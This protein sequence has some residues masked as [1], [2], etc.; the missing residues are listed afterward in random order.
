MR[1]FLISFAL[2]S[3]LL[4]RDLVHAQTSP[5]FTYTS[6]N[7]MIPMRDGVRLFTSI[8]VPS[9][10]Q[11]DLPFLMTRTPY[12]AVQSHD[13][14]HNDYIKDMAS[15]GYIFV[16][17]D[18]RGRNK[19]EG[20]YEMLRPSL[21]NGQVGIDESTDTYDT[22]DWLL[23]NIVGNN[24]KVGMY[25]ISYDGWTTLMGII[26]PHPALK[27]A[28]P[29]ASPADMFLGDDFHHNGA[30][31]LSYS[32]EYAFSQEASKTDTLFPFN[33]YDTFDWYLQ[34]GPLSNVNGKY[35][36]STLPSWNNF[37][38]HPN[39]D[40]FWQRQS[41]TARLSSNNVPILNVAGWWDQEDFYG[42][43][44]I[45]QALEKID[46]DKINQLVIGPWHHGQWAYWLGEK[47]GNINFNSNTGETFRKEIQA[48]WFAYHLK[49]KGKGFT[50]EAV[51]F[52]TGSNRWQHYDKWPPAAM[53]VKNLYIHANGKLSF[54]KPTNKNDAYDYYISD[55][56]HP[57]PYRNRPIEPTN[58]KD[59]RWRAW[60]TED[61][62]FVKDRP[63]VLS[64]QTDPLE[65]D[66][67]VTGRIL[68]NLYAATSGS[69]ADWIV[70]LIDVYPEN[71]PV[72][73][74][75]G[76]YELMVA[77]E[78]FRGRY[79]K[80]FE[81]PQ[82]IKPNQVNL[83]PIDLHQI[84]HVFKKGHRVMVQVQSSWFPLIDR[85]PQ[86]YVPSIFT[87]KQSDYK[88]AIHKISRS[89]RFPTHI[90]LQVTE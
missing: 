83:Y 31:R 2:L 16:F 63:D 45:Y 70:K 12:D 69:D 35:F 18:I 30:F 86:S 36:H 66:L 52:Q 29:Q 41:A 82:P 77:N 71:I 90:Q 88:S 28:S 73:P 78:V 58:S 60:L 50:S 1:T 11:D 14:S 10:H 47:L 65:D 74:T 4:N 44:S 85:N 40:G 9:Q 49:G 19:S 79:R 15:E 23:K 57:V 76:G 13:P 39:Y 24:G 55:P 64:W 20:R 84:D 53:R 6:K 72:E 81:S 46:K 22:I 56:S 67:T 3:G 62:R 26:R 27:A 61:Q 25:G 42:P 48:P 59:S 21:I 32:F 54:T 51:V 43:L 68:A 8:F 75:M 5:T 7:V 33:Y 87:A 89:E 80:S 38:K 37:V 17:Q 34:L